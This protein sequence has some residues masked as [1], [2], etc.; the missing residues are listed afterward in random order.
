MINKLILVVWIVV[1]I[2]LTS[3][4]AQDF[5][6]FAQSSRDQNQLLL[7]RKCSPELL[8]TFIQSGPESPNDQRYQVLISDVAGFVT[9]CTQIESGVEIQEI[10]ETYN[11]VT[12]LLFDHQSLQA[13]IQNDLV[14]FIDRANKTAHEEIIIK[15]FDRGLNAINLTQAFFPELTGA[16]LNVSVKEN[17]FDPQDIDIQS[18]IIPPLPDAMI[19]THATTVATIIVGRGNTARESMGLAPDAGLTSSSFFN[20]MPDDLNYFDDRSIFV[21][22]HSYGIELENYYGLEAMAYDRFSEMRPEVLHIFSAGNEGKASASSGIYKN[23]SGWANLTGNM[24]MAKNVLTVGAVDSFGVSPDAASRGPAYDGRIKPEL[25]TMGQRGSSE[26][27]AVASGTALLL[28]EAYQKKTNARTPPATL[29]KVVMINSADDVGSPGIDFITGFGNLNLYQAINTVLEGRYLEGIALPGEPVFMDI[30]VPEKTKRLKITLGWNDPAATPNAPMALVNDL[31]LT[32]IHEDSTWMPWGLNTDPHADS[33]KKLPIRKR[34]ALNNIEQISLEN[35]GSGRYTI[36]VSPFHL[37]RSE[38]SFY[39][40][41]QMD[42]A[43]S[44]LWIS[45][46]DRESLNAGNETVIRW[47]QNFDALIGRLEFSMDDGAHWNLIDSLVQVQSKYYKWKLPQVF[48]EVRLRMTIDGKVFDS[49]IFIVSEK[50]ELSVDYDCTDDWLL[51][52]AS[53]PEATE[54]EISQWNGRDM[55]FI[56]ATPDTQSIINKKEYTSNYFSVRPLNRKGLA[57][58]RSDAIN[59]LNQG[60]F[61]YLI[62]FFSYLENDRVRLDLSLSSLFELEKIGIEKE[63]NQQFLTIQETTDI[64]GLQLQFFDDQLI[65]GLNVYR[66]VITLKNGME[67]ISDPTGVIFRGNN[68]ALVFPNPVVKDAEI[69]VLEKTSSPGKINLYD[70]F[71]ALI[72]VFQ[73]NNGNSRIPLEGLPA[74]IYY[75]AIEHTG[76]E[77][78]SGHLCVL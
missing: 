56:F 34:D 39:I 54:Y 23:L 76:Q 49:D 69:T 20:L 1:F 70:G 38:Q 53:V 26:S 36:G 16:G 60:L 17:L 61:C 35:P 46:G 71:G 12:C 19:T 30:E 11:L 9:W 22:N 57:G 47:W 68:E 41:Y 67:I 63:M 28:Q 2:F 27:A 66:V 40:S 73:V 62:N 8:Q 45:P 5:S 18:Q 75:Y 25:V 64:S 42:T 13:L 7:Y 29:L 10:N 6:A 65:Q 52:W 78:T 43:R 31:D 33:L 24:K 59:Y 50:T 72:K 74:G 3:M 55:E 58:S 44:F 4:Q 32:L 48:S 15:D 14:L 51:S 21:Q 77:T 37:D